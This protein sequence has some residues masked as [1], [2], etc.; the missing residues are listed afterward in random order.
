M[1]TEYSYSERS[2]V[3]RHVFDGREAVDA[4]WIV[5]SANAFYLEPGHVRVK[6]LWSVIATEQ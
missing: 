3:G 6:R 5:S 2:T 1:M 4:S